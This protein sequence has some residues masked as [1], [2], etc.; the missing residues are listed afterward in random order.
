MENPKQ[1]QWENNIN[2]NRA[3]NRK[4]K[5]NP[6]ANPKETYIASPNGKP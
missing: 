4:H 3:S 1:N 6:I 2:T 5:A